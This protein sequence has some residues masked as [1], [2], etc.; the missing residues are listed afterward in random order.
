[1]RWYHAVIIAVGFAVGGACSGGR[2]VFRPSRMRERW[3]SWSGQTESP[4]VDYAGP[5][6]LVLK[7]FKDGD[8]RGRLW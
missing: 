7:E 3:C 4:R 5:Y 8:S 2:I 1:M 6:G